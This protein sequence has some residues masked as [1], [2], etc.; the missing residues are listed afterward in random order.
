MATLTTA[1][2]SLIQ[3]RAS[4]EIV[5]MV[6]LK[7]SSSLS[8]YFANAAGGLALNEEPISLA[9]QEITPL[10]WE[11]HPHDP[12]LEVQECTFTLAGTEHVRNLV[13]THRLK[14]MEV[15]AK[16]GN[17]GMSSFASHFVPY[18]RGIV[19]DV[20][21]SAQSGTVSIKAVSELQ[22]AKDVRLTGEWYR[23]HPLQI[24]DAIFQAAGVKSALIDSN[25]FDPDDSAYSSTIA[26]WNCGRHISGPADRGV[27]DPQ[28]ALG[29]IEELAKILP[30]SLYVQED[31][32]IT[33]KE[34]DAT[35]T[36]VKTLT[37]ADCRFEQDRGTGPLYNRVRF[38]I[39]W[40]GGG[41]RSTIR[42][43]IDSEANQFDLFVELEDSNSQS[44]HARDGASAYIVDHPRLESRWVGA[45]AELESDLAAAGTSAVLLKKELHDFC[46]MRADGSSNYT[47]SA[48][49]PA[50]FLILSGASNGVRQVEIVKATAC[51][52][53][54]SQYDPVPDWKDGD[55]NDSAGVQLVNKGTFTIARSQLG[56]TAPTTTKATQNPTSTFPTTVFDIT[57][58]VRICQDALERYADGA[59]T[60]WA[61]APLALH[62]DLEVTDL[63]Y[64]TTDNFIAYGYDGLS[65][66]E[67]QITSKTVDPVA[68]TIRF[69]LQVINAPTTSIGYD[70]VKADVPLIPGSL[71]D[72][73]GDDSVTIGA[74]LVDPS[75][76][77]DVRFKPGT[78][79]TSAFGA[80]RWVDTYDHTLTASK[81]NYVGWN[82][83][84]GNPTIEEVTISGTEPAVGATEI[85]LALVTTGAST[86]TSIT[87]LRETGGSTPIQ[88]GLFGGA[89]QGVLNGAFDIYTRDPELYLP[90]FFEVVTGT[91]G[92]DI[93]TEDSNT[94]SGARTLHLINTS[95][96]AKARQSGWVPVQE[97]MIYR[98]G[99]YLSASGT[100]VIATCKV[101]FYQGDKR[102][103]VSTITAFTKSLASAS[104]LEDA[105]SFIQAP[106]NARYARVTVE[107][108][109]TTQHVYV[110]RL[111]FE[112]A[113]VGFDV[114]A[115]GTD[116]NSSLSTAVTIGWNNKN[117]DPAGMFDL[118][119]DE[120]T[121]PVTGRYA[122]AVQAFVKN[123]TT[124]DAHRI[125]V[126]RDTGGGY[127]NFLFGPN[128]ETP[129]ANAEHGLH[130]SWAYV[131]LDKG[132][133]LRARVVT[134]TDTNWD[135]V[136]TTNKTRWSLVQVA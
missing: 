45:A 77:L 108:N 136:R 6:E 89:N 109:T 54:T 83:W 98:V 76:G 68:G 94:F 61:T 31:G 67:C 30:G 96:A 60:L 59:P 18:F 52:P 120:C 46:G 86:L 123:I 19:D 71:F 28:E 64:V 38:D 121:I 93:A 105:F 48:S 134:S 111:I 102:T 110:D 32:T 22:I 91:V 63:V 97:D 114:Y 43:E 90:D 85:R 16:L 24:A 62:H 21:V 129:T 106:T 9:L 12:K 72:P 41:K 130:C 99:G 23:S 127:A 87:D 92:T 42:E 103:S 29:L 88:P 104:T 10:T 117:T 3:G 2:N 116:Q 26:H 51:T 4:A 56:T 15:I 74:E 132:D 80:R 47:L 95:T 40:R 107:K 128:V 113:P 37:D 115:S 17:T 118:T 5:T 13:A 78:A 50:Y 34:W 11:A 124:G 66:Q 8:F 133:L 7:L 58:P 53:S 135:I 82:T 101:E 81:D 112:P 25:A 65:A 119:N 84:T 70:I 57:I 73:R 69:G 100:S 126:D 14:G 79:G 20:E 55:L 36:P 44:N 1:W 75:S 27:R 125:Q 35:D 49:R 131:P 33:F 122:F 39:A